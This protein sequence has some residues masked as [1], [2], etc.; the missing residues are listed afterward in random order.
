MIIS[1]TSMATPH[2]SGT[3]ALMLEA[4]PALTPDQ[5]KT[6]LTGTST[7]MPGYA[8]YQ[9]GAG[10]LNAYEALRTVLVP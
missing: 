6:I 1:G 8:E 10:Y 2:V 4:N 5:V 3:V 7:P 9:A